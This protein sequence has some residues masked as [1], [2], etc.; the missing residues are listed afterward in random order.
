[1]YYSERSR[2]TK[3]QQTLHCLYSLFN[4]VRVIKSCWLSWAGH[5]ARMDE[6][7]SSFKI[8]TGNSTEKSPL[9]SPGR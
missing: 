2:W 5:L 6:G 8:V 7:K 4:I 3:H 1:M 9:E